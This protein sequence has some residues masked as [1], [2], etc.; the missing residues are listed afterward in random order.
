MAWDLSTMVIPAIHYN[1]KCPETIGT[2]FVFISIGA[3]LV[4]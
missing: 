1:K 4:K 2:F 3:R